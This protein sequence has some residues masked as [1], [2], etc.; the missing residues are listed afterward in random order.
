[1]SF[2]MLAIKKKAQMRIQMLFLIP[3]QIYNPTP[4]IKGLS[5]A[6]RHTIHNLQIS[7]WGQGFHS[8]YRLCVC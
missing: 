4:Y 1:M 3:S 8:V 6:P 7:E 2:Q 5:A